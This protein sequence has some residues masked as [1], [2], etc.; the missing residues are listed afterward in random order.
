MSDFLTEYG[1]LPESLSSPAPSLDAVL[2]ACL[3][4]TSDCSTDTCTSDSCPFDACPTDCSD[5]S[6]CSDC[7]DTPTSFS[8]YVYP[9]ASGAT[10][11]AAFDGGDP[12]YEEYRYL[13]IMLNGSSLPGYYRSDNEGGGSSYWD[14]V[15]IDGLEPNTTYTYRVTLYYTDQGSYYPTSYAQEGSF[16]TTEESVWAFIYHNIGWMRSI[17][18]IYHD[19][20][21]MTLT[22]YMMHNGGWK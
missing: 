9:S 18:Y 8:V 14:N 12:S 3:A 22:P 21:W 19:G 6:D 4:D 7:G 11:M 13:K 10:I 17:P 15:K 16:T 1:S 20:K 5:C 2:A